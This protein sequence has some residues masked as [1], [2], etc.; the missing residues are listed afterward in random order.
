MNYHIISTLIKVLI[1]IVI[2][3]L[4]IPF[5]SQTKIRKSFLYSS[6]LNSSNML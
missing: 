5:Y 1:L 6:S 2:V 3:I 4:F